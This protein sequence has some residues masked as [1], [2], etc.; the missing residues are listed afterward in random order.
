MSIISMMSAQG[1]MNYC[2]FGPDTIS[3]LCALDTVSKK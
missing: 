1:M 3:F 2:L